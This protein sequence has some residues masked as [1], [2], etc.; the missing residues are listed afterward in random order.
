MKKR[1]YLQL[2]AEGEGESTDPINGGSNDPKQE[3][4]GDKG[5]EPKYTDA[6]LDEIINKKFA[7]WQEKKQKEV[8]EA[9]KLAE[10]NATQRAEHERDELQKELEEYKRK[11][12][13]AEMTKTARGMLRENDISVSDELLAMFV[14]EEAEQTKAA[15]DGFVKAFKEAV[16]TAVKEKIK[17][18]PP[19]KGSGGSTVMTKEQIMAIRDPELRQAKMLEHKG[20][21]NI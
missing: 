19:R 17:G 8:D 10:M 20:L 6:D 2:F 14:S 3:G 9:K 4:E 21:F 12:S 1:I 11:D 16:E 5:G 13:L 18:E 15:V 7:K